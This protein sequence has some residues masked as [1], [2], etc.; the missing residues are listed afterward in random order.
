MS[1]GPGEEQIK[2]ELRDMRTAMEQMQHDVRVLTNP[3]KRI[4]KYTAIPTL[5]EVLDAADR[6][7]EHSAALAIIRTAAIFHLR[8][9]LK[10]ALAKP[11]LRIRWWYVD[12]HGHEYRFE[13]QARIFRMY[14]LTEAEMCALVREF[15]EHYACPWYKLTTTS[16]DE[17]TACCVPTS[18]R[19]RTVEN[20]TAEQLLDPTDL[21]WTRS[22]D[23]TLVVGYW[24]RVGQSRLIVERKGA[25]TLGATEPEFPQ[26]D[27]SDPFV[28]PTTPP[29]MCVY[30]EADR[31]TAAAKPGYFTL[32]TAPPPE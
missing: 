15:V 7:P 30:P 31:A 6:V 2:R 21:I 27:A 16:T 19:V 23:R 26:L 25:T 18:S 28:T 13:D 24:L 17:C 11:D 10:G 12:S 29:A 1:H 4:S 32:P 8:Q 14:Y 22:P 5:E 3:E 20:G 9:Q